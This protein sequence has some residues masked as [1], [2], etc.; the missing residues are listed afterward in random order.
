M[1]MSKPNDHIAFD[2]GTLLALYVI[3]Q[4]HINLE[5]YL[6]HWNISLAMIL[7]EIHGFQKTPE[8]A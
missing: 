2:S 1:H 5:V 3:T 6:F 8:P 4:V 7:P